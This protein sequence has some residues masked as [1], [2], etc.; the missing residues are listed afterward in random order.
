M[1]ESVCRNN[2]PCAARWTLHHAVPAFFKAGNLII[3]NSPIVSFIVAFIPFFLFSILLLNCTP[4]QNGPVSK[5]DFMMGTYVS[6]TC[7]DYDVE[8]AQI[9]SAIEA[10]F[11]A[12]KK[13]EAK[14]NPYDERSLISVINRGKDEHRVV[15]LDSQL[16]DLAGQ[17]ID[18][19]QKSG[20]TFD[21]TLWPVF[22]L[23]NF[24]TDSAQIPSMEVIATALNHVD[25]RK[26]KL[27]SLSLLI[28]AGVEIDF[29][30]ISKGYAVETARKVLLAK[31]LKNF[32]I[33]A[34]GNL[35]I[36]WEKS[37][38]M[39]VIV[40]HPRKDGVFWGEFPISKSCG[41]ATSGDYHFYF[42][43]DGRRYHHLLNPETGYPAENAVS[44]TIIA[45]TATLAD[46]FSTAVFVMGID[47]GKAFITANPDL[48]GLII[49]QDTDSLQTYLSPALTESFKFSQP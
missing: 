45:P 49:Y 38:P 31:G 42:M 40:R 44:T 28:D 47:A 5:T 30:G 21:F 27:D 18:I 4:Q 33:D 25:Y 20:A 15:K 34:G 10:A 7:H 8:E 37:Q 41:I 16:A 3:S 9:N 39:L 14:T 32:I 35:G 26:V 2:H 12:I 19:A 46:G 36:E 22:R 11:A 13:I 1:V 23:W 29:N 48:E 43:S 6:I 17:A 24:D